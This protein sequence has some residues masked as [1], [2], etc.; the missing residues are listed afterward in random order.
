MRYLKKPVYVNA[1][2]FEYSTDGMNKLIR[3]I[4]YSKIIRHGA[5]RL[6]TKGGWVYL[7]LMNQL[8][9]IDDGDYVLINEDT[10]EVSNM[11]ETEFKEIYI[12]I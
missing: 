4:P 12:D 5:Q 2:K 3:F 1:I 11:S 8:L 6:P 10:D 9:V 7:S